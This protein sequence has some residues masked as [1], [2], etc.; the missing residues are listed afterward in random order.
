M[1]SDRA[2]C[3]W[4]L[5]TW[6]AGPRAQGGSCPPPPLAPPMLVGD[7]LRSLH[8]VKLTE[9][10]ADV[11][12]PRKQECS[13]E[14]VVW[15]NT[16]VI[17]TSSHYCS[18]YFCVLYI[19]LCQVLELLQYNMILNWCVNIRIVQNYL[20]DL[21]DW[22]KHVELF[23]ELDSLEWVHI[24]IQDETAPTVEQIEHFVSLID[25]AESEGTVRY[26]HVLPASEII[27]VLNIRTML[28]GSSDVWVQTP[29]YI[30]Q[31]HWVLGVN[32]L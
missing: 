5:A 8:P 10:W 17:S 9:Q 6:G 24:P 12:E 18:Y 19:N 30:P 21:W 13:L 2:L 28:I 1:D 15:T 22:L 7:P 31:N 32:P 27:S 25:K 4:H 23:V 11:V 3:P 20:L 16:L 29:G 14:N 26:L